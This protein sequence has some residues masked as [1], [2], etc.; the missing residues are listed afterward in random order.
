MTPKWP[1]G[2]PIWEPP[3]RDLTAAVT[4]LL[5]S[6][7]TYCDRGITQLEDAANEDPRP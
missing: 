7:Q 5:A 3:F 6:Y 4:R 2:D 1:V